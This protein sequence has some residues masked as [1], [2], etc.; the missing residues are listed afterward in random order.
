MYQVI[1][2]DFCQYCDAAQKELEKRELD[3]KYR[4]LNRFTKRF[5][6]RRRL[7]SVPQIWH[8]GEY[9]GGYRELMDHLNEQD[10]VVHP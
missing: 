4:K 3:F 1:G 2:H 7:S 5:F 6:Y 8:N 10:M 9:I